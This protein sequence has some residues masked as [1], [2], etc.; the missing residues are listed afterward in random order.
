MGRAN[1]DETD[2][3][4]GPYNLRQTSVVGTYPGGVSPYGV[5]DMAGNVWEWCVDARDGKPDEDKVSRVL[6]GGSWYDDHVNARA[7]YRLGLDPDYRYGN[8]GFRVVCASPIH[9]AL[10]TETLITAPL[11][12]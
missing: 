7:T 1:I 12:H 11:R 6:R 8:F 9:E 10:V 4:A 5:H 2:G 3:K